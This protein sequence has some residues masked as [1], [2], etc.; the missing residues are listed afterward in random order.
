MDACQ[1]GPS[2]ESQSLER[3]QKQAVQFK[4]VSASFF[5]N[6]LIENGLRVKIDASSQENI[7]IFKRD[8]VEM[9]AMQ[10]YQCVWGHINR[11]VKIDARQVRL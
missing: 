5:K 1:Q 4:T 7:K 3:L 10:S 2:L 9:G 8:G 11:P 6:Q